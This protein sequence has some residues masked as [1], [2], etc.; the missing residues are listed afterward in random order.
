LY[1]WL[2]LKLGK[3]PE[4]GR[5]YDYQ[6]A[7]VES[8]QFRCELSIPPFNLFVVGDE[9]PRKIAAEHSAAQKALDQ[10]GAPSIACSHQDCTAGQDTTYKAELYRWLALKLGKVPEAGRDYDY[11][12]ATVESGQFRCELSIPPFNL[13]VVGDE[14]PRKIAAEHSAAQKA[15]DQVGA[16]SIEECLAAFEFAVTRST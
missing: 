6:T 13:F 11:Q 16:P 15:L 1:R 4:A 10:V 9:Q 2:A 3:V 14:Q 7:T 5:D 12:T 8:G